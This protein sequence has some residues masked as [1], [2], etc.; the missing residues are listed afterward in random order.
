MWR[1]IDFEAGRPKRPFLGILGSKTY[2]KTITGQ[3]HRDHGEPY[4]PNF[5]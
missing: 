5:A 2:R 4:A 1:R 3:G